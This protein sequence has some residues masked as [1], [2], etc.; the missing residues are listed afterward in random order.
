MIDRLTVLNETFT[1]KLNTITASFVQMGHDIA[2]AQHMAQ[3]SL[4]QQLMQQATLSAF[5]TSYR[6]Y[7]IIVICV[8]PLVFL[9]RKVKQGQCPD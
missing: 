2:T 1:V 5:M 4:Y 6:T 8:L 7:A 3:I 9:L